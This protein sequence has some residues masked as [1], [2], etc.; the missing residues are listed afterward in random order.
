MPDGW[1]YLRIASVCVI[2]DGDRGK[3]YP[4][5]DEFT[6]EGYCLFLSAKNVR[7]NGFAFTSNQFVTKEKHEAL[8]KGTAKRGDVIFTSRGTI[9]NI[10]H[11]DA[12]VPYEVMRINSGMFI[13]REFHYAMTPKFLA[14]LLRSPQIRRQI[15][16]LQSGSAQPQLPIG[17]FRVFVAAIP[18]LKEQ[19]AIVEVL[20]KCLGFVETSSLLQATSEAELTQLDQSSLAKAFRGELVPQD[21]SDEPASQ[22]LHRIRTTRAQLEAEKKAAKKKSKKKATRKKNSKV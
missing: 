21:P 11:Y 18:P 4:K 7:P 22:L 14:H 8:R 19:E 9:G 2:E 12:S 13:L 17:D 20:E 3:A 1:C 16:N 6:D 5:K 15:E 10:A